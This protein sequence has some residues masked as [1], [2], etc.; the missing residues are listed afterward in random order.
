MQFSEVLCRISNQHFCICDDPCLSKFGALHGGSCPHSVRQ[1]VGLLCS[2]YLCSQKVHPLSPVC[3]T[4]TH[5]VSKR[6]RDTES[7]AKSVWKKST[8]FSPPNGSGLFSFQNLSVLLPPYNNT[9]SS[10]VCP[11]R[12]TVFC[13]Y[14]FYRDQL[15]LASDIR[16]QCYRNIDAS[17]CV[18][19][20]L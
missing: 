5:Q 13:A 1:F 7:D 3:R 16:T 19:V 17:V 10:T 2:T 20:V 4:C 9:Y 12:Q 14:L 6:G 18:E 11:I 8:H 15:L